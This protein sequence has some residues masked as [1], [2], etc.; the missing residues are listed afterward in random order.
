MER[1]NEDRIWDAKVALTFYPNREEEDDQASITDLI[2]DLYHLARSL[3]LDPYDVSRV[4]FDHYEAE[5]AG[6][7]A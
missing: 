1:L 4:A 6:V 7:E 5:K 3:D 2:A